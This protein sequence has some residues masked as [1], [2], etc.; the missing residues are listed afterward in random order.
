MDGITSEVQGCR[1]NIGYIHIGMS[2]AS[3]TDAYTVVRKSYMHGR[4]VFFGVNSH[5][6][7]AHVPQGTDDPDSDLASGGDKY[8][9]GRH[10]T[11]S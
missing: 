1:N 9:P 3:F 2:A 8:A 4:G 10:V 6:C 11:A 7:N 5:G